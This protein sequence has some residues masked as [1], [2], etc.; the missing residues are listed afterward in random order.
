MS[1]GCPGASRGSS[2]TLPA[3]AAGDAMVGRRRV[4][5][6]RDV[7]T[8]HV[9]RD[10]VLALPPGLPLGR[11]Q[12]AAPFFVA[13]QAA[14]AVVGS[15]GGRRGQPV[16]VVAR[17]AAEL[18]LALAETAARFHLLDL[19]D[20]L[21][22]AWLPFFL[23][24]TAKNRCNGRPGRKSKRLTARPGEAERALQMALLADRIPQRGG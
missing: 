23:T 9:A 4:G 6:V 5:D 1:A 11:W 13:L 19:P 3:S 21:E 16:R 2:G 10:A 12:G 7:R 17:D 14:L 20:H 22:L 15:L 18:A 8:R 24:K